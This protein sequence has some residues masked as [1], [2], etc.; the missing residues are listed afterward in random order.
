MSE[1]LPMPNAR[2]RDEGFAPWREIG[3]WRR[4]FWFSLALNVA[5]IVSLLWRAW[6][7]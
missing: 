4:R 5:L 6:S 7:A 3:R 1:Y 2:S